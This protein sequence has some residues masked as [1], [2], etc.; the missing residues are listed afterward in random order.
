MTEVKEQI[1]Q[2]KFENEVVANQV[3]VYLF[4]SYKEKYDKKTKELETE[5]QKQTNIIA[6]LEKQLNNIV[7]DDIE[8]ATI[9][10][11][12]L[13]KKIG[14]LYHI[15]NPPEPYILQFDNWEAYY[16]MVFKDIIEIKDKIRKIIKKN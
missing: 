5:N 12:E 13:Q 11:K 2:N 3:Q 4:K 6:D 16:R 1:M 8:S 14:N 7:N 10:D 15:D 9:R